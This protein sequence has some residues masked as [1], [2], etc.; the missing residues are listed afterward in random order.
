MKELIQSLDVREVSA[1]EIVQHHLEEIAQHDPGIHAFITV[2]QEGA[3]RQ[4]DDADRRRAQG[5]ALSPFDGI[6]IA[7][8]DNISTK[9]L[10]TTCGSRMLEDYVPLFDATVISRLRR[11]GLVLVGKTNLDEFA[12]GSSTEYSAFGVTHNPHD[13]SR[14][15]GGSSGGSAAAVAA[16][17][18]P[19]SL[20]TDTGGSIRQPA[21]FCGVVGLKPTYGWVSRYGVV[22][23]APS[24][25]QVGPMAKRV[26]D[27]AALFALIAGNDPRDA[28]SAKA[29]SFQVPA[30][31]PE[32]LRDLRVGVPE[33][34]FSA[35]LDSQVEHAVRGCLRQL[36]DQ[37]AVLQP[38]SLATNAY[39]ID[40]YLTLV[41]AEASSCLARYDGV[42]YGKRVEAEDSNT[43]FAKSRSAGFGS[44]VKRRLMLGTYVLSANHYEAYYEQAQKVRTLI[45]EDVLDAL[46][47][48]DVIITPTTPTAAFQIGAK[49]DPLEM[50]LSDL[51]TAMANL[52]GIPA[53]SVP[54]G[55]NS[56][57]LPMGIQ[58]MGGNFSE[59]LLF[60][61]GYMIEQGVEGSARHGQL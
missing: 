12:M 22:A 25:D 4:A 53:L 61:V 3:L 2:D 42:R 29:P 51:F 23:L 14:V 56:H 35:G 37:G 30:W 24:L 18:V 8:K 41:T 16:G 39:A 58:I 46:S 40:T 60:Q 6:P 52:S 17:E 57:G 5:Q 21:S 44:E 20:G 27:A 9:G 28:T 13:H 15:P 38:L 33:E 54:C 19:W 26:E 31:D 49:R 11:A 1:Q 7:V 55:L 50:Y 34:F 47:Q 48:V 45:K 32:V 36:E 10:R 43:M 59:A